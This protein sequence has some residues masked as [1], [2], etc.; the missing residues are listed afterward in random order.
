MKKDIKSVHCFLQYTLISGWC[1][2]SNQGNALSELMELQN[3]TNESIQPL[4][5]DS[6]K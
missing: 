1:A 6:L 5:R 4:P 2:F 3:T